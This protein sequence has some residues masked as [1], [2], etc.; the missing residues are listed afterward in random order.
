MVVHVGYCGAVG[1]RAGELILSKG[2][3][4]GPSEVGLLA[5][6]GIA[7]VQSINLLASVSGPLRKADLVDILLIKC[8][9]S[10]ILYVNMMCRYHALSSQW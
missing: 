1:G 10:G 5:T 9:T 3:R 2:D 8:V 6:I 4:I 7:E